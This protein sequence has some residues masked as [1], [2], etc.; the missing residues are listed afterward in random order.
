MKKNKLTIIKKPYVYIWL[1]IISGRF[2]DIIYYLI[3]N[4]NKRSFD[5]NN[6]DV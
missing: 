4:L 2:Q 5:S 3:S 6:S 1:R